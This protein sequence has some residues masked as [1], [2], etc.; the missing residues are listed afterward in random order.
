MYHPTSPEK[1]DDIDLNCDIIMDPRLFK[2]GSNLSAS[3]NA[4]SNLEPTQN[5]SGNFMKTGNASSSGHSN[6]REHEID[7]R[8]DI[9]EEELK[10]NLNL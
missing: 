3:D 5:V 9:N 6:G 4:Q 1:T 10:R 8:A 2:S 7:S